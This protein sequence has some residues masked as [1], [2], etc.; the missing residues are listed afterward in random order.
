MEIKEIKTEKCPFC[1]GIGRIP[2]V[3][4][5]RVRCKDC[6]DY[7]HGC[8]GS[9]NKGGWGYEFCIRDSKENK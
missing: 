1:D 4:K 5:I 8:F 9:G 6:Q 3:K 2:I 7:N